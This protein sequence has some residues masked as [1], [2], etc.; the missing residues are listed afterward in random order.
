MTM[1]EKRGLSPVIATLL[2]VMLAVVLA[3]IIFFYMRSVVGEKIVK[4]D[5]AIEY[6]C[7][8]IDFAADA[9]NKTEKVDIRISN[10]GNVPIYSFVVKKISLGSVDEIPLSSKPESANA[11]GSSNATVSSLAKG[12]NIIIVPVL[13]GESNGLRKPYNCEDK[14]G[15]QVIVQ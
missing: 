12:D 4:F 13:L 10:R 8:K 5:Q 9:I 14:D 3:S 11:G 1:R 6:S 2:L 7:S 15:E